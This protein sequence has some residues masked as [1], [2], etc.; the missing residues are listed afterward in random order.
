MHP[1]G[2]FVLIEDA[3]AKARAMVLRESV[4]SLTDEVRL[5]LLDTAVCDGDY[6]YCPDCDRGCCDDCES[7]GDGKAEGYDEGYQ[8]ALRQEG[9]AETGKT[10]NEEVLELTQQRIKD[11]DDERKAKKQ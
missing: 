1:D 9:N 4:N 3:M 8:D 7:Y 5:D 2:G 11:A 10:Y 6:G